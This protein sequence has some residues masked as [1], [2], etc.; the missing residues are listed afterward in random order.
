[1]SIPGAVATAAGGLMTLAMAITWAVK[2]NGEDS[3]DVAATVID[4]IPGVVKWV[5]MMVTAPPANVIARAALGAVDVLCGLTTV[6]LTMY[7]VIENQ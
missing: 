6:G 3:S 5:P 1:M 2:K 4:G 7:G